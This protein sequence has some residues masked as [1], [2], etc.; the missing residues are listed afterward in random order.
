MNI[1]IV[2]RVEKFKVICVGNSLIPWLQGAI[3]IAGACVRWLR[4]NMGIISTSEEIGTL[5]TLS[6]CSQVCLINRALL[7]KLINI[8]ICLVYDPTKCTI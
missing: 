8:I 4:D 1:V 7:Y 3:A 2:T 5:S 6:Y